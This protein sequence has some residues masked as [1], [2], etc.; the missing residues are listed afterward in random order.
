MAVVLALLALLAPGAVF[1][2]VLYRGPP[3]LSGLVELEMLSAD[4][5][6]SCCQ[7]WK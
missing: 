4:V 7:F 1:V 2:S 3:A 5:D 6:C